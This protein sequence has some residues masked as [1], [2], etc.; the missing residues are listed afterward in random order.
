MGNKVEE[1]GK[2]EMESDRVWGCRRRVARGR[3]YGITLPRYSATALKHA[4]EV[5]VQNEE[6]GNDQEDEA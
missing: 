5:N 3:Q 2:R 1:T 6:E 4:P